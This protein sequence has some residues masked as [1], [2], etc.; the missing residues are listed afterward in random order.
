MVRPGGTE[1]NRARHSGFRIKGAARLA[2]TLAS[3]CLICKAVLAEK[4]K[5]GATPTDLY[6]EDEPDYS[7]PDSPVAVNV[8]GESVTVDKDADADGTDEGTLGSALTRQR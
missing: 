7:I 2:L 3:V 1:K 4:V 6:G 5:D 8:E